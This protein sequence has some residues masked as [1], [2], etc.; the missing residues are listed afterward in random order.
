MKKSMVFLLTIMATLVFGTYAFADSMVVDQ[1]YAIIYG[2]MYSN[3]YSG[4]N[5]KHY[6][7]GDDTNG[8]NLNNSGEAAEE[9]WLEAL[10][11]LAYNNPTVN[12]LSKDEDSNPLDEVPSNW[13]Y[14]VLKYGNGAGYS[15]D[16]YAIQNDSDNTLELSDV[17]LGNQAL[18]HVTYF[19]T[20]SVPEPAT[21]LLLGVALVGLAGVSRKYKK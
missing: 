11:G 5:L 20:T 21:M 7:D 18:S 15:Y 1:D 19:G 10:L 6:W 2:S 12:I 4:P 16:H 3:Y 9:A 17:G 14:A 8:Q 13:T